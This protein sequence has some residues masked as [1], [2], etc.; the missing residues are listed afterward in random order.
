MSG[1]NCLGISVPN[2]PLPVMALS[3][4]IP[5]VFQVLNDL[6]L[7][8]D[9]AESRLWLRFFYQQWCLP[10]AF[11]PGSCP[12]SASCH[13]LLRRFTLIRSPAILILMG[14]NKERPLVLHAPPQQGKG[15]GCVSER[16]EVS[17]H[18]PLGGSCHLDMLVLV[19]M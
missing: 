19:Q 8:S 1:T 7:R 4:F 11:L 10:P 16:K 13:M 5:S 17:A 14:L 2:T 3:L 12:E 6:R 15:T 9:L 18:L